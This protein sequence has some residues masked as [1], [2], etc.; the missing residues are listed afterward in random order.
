MVD[1]DQGEEVK[2]S[3]TERIEENIVRVPFSGCWIWMK[4]TLGKGYGQYTHPGRKQEGAHRVAYRAFVGPIE[5]GKHVCHVCDTPSC[6]NPAHLFLGTPKENTQDCIKKGRLNPGKVG[7]PRKLSDKDIA[8]IVRLRSSGMIQ[9]EIGDLFGVS[10]VRIS[11]LI[12][13]RQCVQ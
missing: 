6:C 12:R 2:H 4:S 9:R 1:V 5:Q 10:Q 3:I 8:D 7:R 11:Q 13:K